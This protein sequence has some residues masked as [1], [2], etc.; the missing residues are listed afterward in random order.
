MSVMIYD[1]TSQS[2]KEAE[3]PKIFSP[4]DGAWRETTGLVYDS[5]SKAWEEKWGTQV[6]AYVYGAASETITI[7]KNGII[8]ATVQTDS[9]GKSTKQIALSDGTYTL[10]G[11]ISGWTE[12]QTVDENTTKFRAMPE[13]ALYWYG[14]ECTWITGGWRSV[15]GESCITFRT[16]DIYATGSY[17]AYNYVSTNTKVNLTGFSEFNCKFTRG[18]AVSQNGEPSIVIDS[19][20]NRN[21]ITG[22][23]FVSGSAAYTNYVGSCSF[24]QRTDSQYIGIDLSGNVGYHHTTNIFYLLLK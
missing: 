15:I 16:N 7:R 14:N 5:A 22:V 23:G 6:S 11:S 12:E 21:I 17:D 4:T 8:V 18:A 13:G 1:N 24:S 3:T 9:T 10:T 20:G 19:T 2:F